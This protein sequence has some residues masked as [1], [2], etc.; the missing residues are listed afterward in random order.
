MVFKMKKNMK[1]DTDNAIVQQSY[2]DYSRNN[3]LLAKQTI[4]FSQKY[5]YHHGYSVLRLLKQHCDLNISGYHR[6]PELS[7]T[8][9]HFLFCYVIHNAANNSIYKTSMCNLA[10][11]LKKFKNTYIYY[12][13]PKCVLCLKIS[14]KA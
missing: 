14:R 5:I 6:Q 1:Q 8:I 7:V 9:L 13:S 12:N 2:D 11:L 3:Q 4:F 10:I